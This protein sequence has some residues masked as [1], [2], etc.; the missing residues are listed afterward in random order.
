MRS[1]R[2]LSQLDSHSKAECLTATP[3]IEKSPDPS[4]GCNKK[5]RLSKAGIT[6]HN[7]KLCIHLVALKAKWKSEVDLPKS[8]KGDGSMGAAVSIKGS[9]VI[10]MPTRL[11][12][13]ATNVAKSS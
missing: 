6:P 4:C 10:V 1:Q 11:G 5:Q 12:R 2:F 8:K 7:K 13:H 3:R 9:D